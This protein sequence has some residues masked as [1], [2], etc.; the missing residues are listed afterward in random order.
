MIAGAPVEREEAFFNPLTGRQE[1]K[2]VLSQEQGENLSTPERLALSKNLV[3]SLG[4]SKML[5][6]VVDSDPSG[7]LSVA[8]RDRL[9]DAQ[10]SQRYRV[11]DMDEDDDDDDGDFDRPAGPREDEAHDAETGVD[12]SA[13]NFN[14][15]ER[16][17]FGFNSG[18]FHPR[19]GRG[20]D[21]Y[22]GDLGRQRSQGF[23]EYRQ[24][25]LPTRPVAASA[26]AAVRSGFDPD[27][28]QFNI[29]VGVPARRPIPKAPTQSAVIPT[30]R[31]ELPTDRQ[32]FAALAQ[33]INAAGGINGTPIRVND[34]SSV[35]NIRKNFIKRLN[36]AGNA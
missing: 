23:S 29:Q 33:R 31:S 19:N 16:Q 36:L 20:E 6:Y 34:G 35:A 30:R 14:E 2:T 3:S 11:G 22:F 10:Q 25:L 8:Q 32:G 9:F 15:D 4:F 18:M 26:S 1:T 28:Q 5:K 17:R 13:R 12:R 24:S 21:T 27:T 7:L